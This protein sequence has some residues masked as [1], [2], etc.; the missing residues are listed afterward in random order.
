MANLLLASVN[1]NVQCTSCHSHHEK[2]D[3]K[4]HLRLASWEYREGLSRASTRNYKHHT[5]TLCGE[6]PATVWKH[7]ENDVRAYVQVE[8]TSLELHG[9]CDGVPMACVGNPIDGGLPKAKQCQDC[10][11]VAM[12]YFT[13]MKLVPDHFLKCDKCGTWLHAKNSKYYAYGPYDT[14]G[15]GTIDLDEYLDSDVGMEEGHA[16]AIRNYQGDCQVICI[17][18]HHAQYPPI[19]PPTSFSIDIDPQ[20]G[21]LLFRERGVVL[22]QLRV[23]L[24]NH[25]T[26]IQWVGTTGTPLKGHMI[27]DNDAFEKLCL[28]FLEQRASRKRLMGGTQYQTIQMERYT[29]E[30]LYE[31][32]NVLECNICGLTFETSI[33]LDPEF[34]KDCD[35]NQKIKSWNDS[36]ARSHGVE[37]QIDS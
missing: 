35:Q 23:S 2:T 18:C 15:G 30:G 29:L 11:E 24:N 37:P 21:F 7:Q 4:V 14:D 5:K 16:Q 31:G 9:F 3:G 13:G 33:F 28:K 22:H 26:T 17:P 19:E 25:E 6:F 1:A 36:A 10:S 8:R 27:I 12:K 32:G 20:A 34:H